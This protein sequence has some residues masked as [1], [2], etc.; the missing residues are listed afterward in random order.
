[1]KN[2]QVVLIDRPDD[3]PAPQNFRLVESEY[4]ELP[5]DGL[6]VRNHF[7]SI[8]PAMRGWICDLNNYLPPVAIDS[9]MRSLAVGEVVASSSSD[10]AVGEFVTGWFGWQDFAAVNVDAVIR[11]VLLSEGELSASLSVLGIN[12]ITAYQALKTIGRLVKGETVVVS[13]AAGSVGSIVGQLA[14]RAGCK[15]IGLTGSDEKVEQ[16]VKHFG[17]SAAINYKS[18]KSLSKAVEVHAKQGVDVFFDNTAGEI[19]DSI[20]PLMNINGRVIQCGTASISSWDPIPVGPRRER[21]ILTK[22]LLLQGF[23]VFDHMQQWPK[24]ITDL[25]ESVRKGDIYYREDIRE[26]LLEAPKALSDLY[27]GKNQGKTIIKLL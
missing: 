18:V 7:L 23:V 27:S 8:D 13:T 16:C 10:Y 22:R 3:I 25:S 1:M 26:G 5:N 6:I 12:G 14:H 20:Y 21:Y 11:K 2:K 15:V 9:V 17:Y 24:I 19:A 4:P